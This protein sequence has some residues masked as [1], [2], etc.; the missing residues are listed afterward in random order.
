M[1]TS[2]TYAFKDEVV[3]YRITNTLNGSQYIGIT[4]DFHRRVRQ[5]LGAKNNS[6]KTRIAGAIRKYGGENFTFEVVEGFSDRKSALAREIEII[7]ATKPRYNV[8]SG[9]DGV[10][11]PISSETR[12]K[13]S[14]TLTGRPSVW[15]GRKHSAEARAKMSAAAM[16]RVGPKKGEKRSKDVCEKISA[17]LRQNPVR[18]WL[19]KQRNEETKSKISATKRAAA[20]SRN[21][22]FR[23]M[24][25]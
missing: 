14:A 8:T 25:F 2:G 21:A 16:G 12:Q 15:I 3:I 4:E 11:M 18:Y 19:G 9:G 23:N 24:E 1:T 13:I 5:H 20:E 10:R 6:K 22:E 7:E 17:S